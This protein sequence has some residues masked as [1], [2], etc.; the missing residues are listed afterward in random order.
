MRYPRLFKQQNVY[1]PTFFGWLTIFIISL[2]SLFIFANSI[3]PFLA[4]CKPINSKVFIIEGWLPDYCLEQFINNYNFDDID[5]IFVTGGPLEQG[6]YLKEYNSF[7]A[8]GAQTLKRLGI[9][10][11]LIIEVPAPYVQKDRTFTSALA[12]KKFISNSSTIDSATIIT[13]GVHSRRSQLL[14]Q[15]A[16]SDSAK[17]GVVS[18]RNRDYDPKYWYV[19]SMGLKTVIVEIISYIYTKLFFSKFE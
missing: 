4:V 19:S 11:S 13:L 15:K 17:I 3:H 14:F 6:S 7:A 2:T 16:F 12:L 1:F 10:D 5:K 18:I 9:T 8:V